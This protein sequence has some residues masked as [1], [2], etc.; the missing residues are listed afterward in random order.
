MRHNTNMKWIKAGD[1]HKT[2]VWDNDTLIYNETREPAVIL[3][4]IRNTINCILQRG[5]A[6]GQ[7]DEDL[8]D[9]VLD[10]IENLGLKHVHDFV[11][12][13]PDLDFANNLDRLDEEL[14]IKHGDKINLRTKQMAKRTRKDYFSYELGVQYLPD[15]DAEDNEFAKFVHTIFLDP[16]EYEF[17]RLL[18]GKLVVPDS[19]SNILVL[20]QHELGGGGKTIWFSCFSEVLYRRSTT[21]S[22]E[23]FYD[24]CRRNPDFE[25]AKL[26]NKT[27]AFVDEIRVNKKNKKKEVPVNLARV[28]DLTGGGMRSELDKYQKASSS[29]PKKQTANIVLL[30]NGNFFMNKEALCSSMDRR[31]IYFTTLPIFRAR[32]SKDYDVNNQYCFEK[33]PNLYERLMNHKD[34]IFTFLVNATCDYLHK[35]KTIKTFA[36]KDY[37]PP[38][39]IKLWN[40]LVNEINSFEETQFKLFLS[41]ECKFQHGTLECIDQ[42]IKKLLLFI[43]ETYDTARVQYNHNKIRELFKS[44]IIT[45]PHDDIPTITRTYERIGINGNNGHNKNHRINKNKRKFYVQNIGYRNVKY[46]FNI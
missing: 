35:K 3:R 32:N 19:H 23:I 18:N 24:N 33:D 27:V 6:T 30:G 38:R 29:I 28:Q 41:Q 31:V 7:L 15:L 8:E 40:T 42:F 20:W 13:K 12:L 21:L 22:R 39:F 26:Y 16:E 5:I 43:S 17:F 2:Y 14:P 4:S 10:I 36:L 46:D 9:E 37:Q 1:K 34:H 44:Y 25:I 11:L 45:F